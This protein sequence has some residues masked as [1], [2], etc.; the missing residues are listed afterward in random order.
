M[1][2]IFGLSA[3]RYS[4]ATWAQFAEARPDM[5]TRGFNLFSI[6]LAYRATV[7]I[8]G[9]PRLHPLSPIFADGRLFVAIQ[10][11]SPRRFDLANDRRYSLHGLPPILGPDYDEFEIN[12]TGKA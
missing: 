10:S 12:L 7:R 6:P 5:A 4:M 11:S 1:T 8:D 9:A 3:R 2:S